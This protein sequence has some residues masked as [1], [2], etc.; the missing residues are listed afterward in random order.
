MDLEVSVH[1]Q[2]ASLF[3]RPMATKIIMV[4]VH[5]RGK[6]LISRHPASTKTARSQNN[7]SFKGMHLVTYFLQPGP[8]S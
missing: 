5:G 2:L 1:G 7:I 4:Y 6:L 8:T 3:L